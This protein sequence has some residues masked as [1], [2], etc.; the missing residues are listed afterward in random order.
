MKTVR[1]ILVV[2]HRSRPQVSG[3][4]DELRPLLESEGEVE[5]LDLEDLE[6]RRGNL[7][8]DLALIVGGDGSILRAAR[9]LAPAGVPCMGVNMGRLGFLASYQKSDMAE[10]FPG[11]MNGGGRRV[12][13]MMLNVRI[14]SAGGNCQEIPALN[15]VL[16]SH[17]ERHRMIGLVLDIDGQSVATFHGDGALVSTP[18]GSTGHNLAAGGPILE[19]RLESMVI[20][21]VCPHTLSNRSIVIGGQS[22]VRV[23][24]ASHDREAT[25]IVDGQVQ[26]PIVRGDVVQIEKAV[27]KFVLI[28]NPRRTGYDTLR[29]KLHWSQAPHYSK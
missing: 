19:S 16:I 29:E 11:L 9:S 25:C 15:D 4:I 1:K 17:G 18:T 8:A 5:V 26:L 6:G 20:T 28:E 2:G 14:E 12:E 21:P 7:V 24:L 10:S 13:R 27:E 22:C 3:T 23:S